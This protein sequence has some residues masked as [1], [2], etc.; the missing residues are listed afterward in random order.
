MSAQVVS[1]RVAATW[2]SVRE[3]W[4]RAQQ[5]GWEAVREAASVGAMLIELKEQHDHGEFMANYQ[6]AG[7]LKR[8]TA[9]NLMKLAR[10]LPLL[11]KHKPDSQRAALALIPVKRLTKEEEKQRLIRR[12]ERE[13]REQDEEEARPRSEEEHRSRFIA[14]AVNAREWARLGFEG[15]HVDQ[16][17][18][19]WARDAA[20]AWEYLAVQLE[21]RTR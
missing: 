17:L 15:K 8:Q 7:I 16:E 9:Q 6:R 3:A 19:D 10:H 14:R 5:K 18:V 20:A 4:A 1:L 21:E 11:E 12:I 13:R 2:D